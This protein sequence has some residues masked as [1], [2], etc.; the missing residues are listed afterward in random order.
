MDIL[1]KVV[2]PLGLAFIM[3]SL[4]L[5]LKGADFYRVIQRPTSFFI[6]A[7]NQMILLPIVAFVIIIAFGISGELAVGLM[8]LAA[9]PG[10][11]TSNILSR[12]AKADVAL[13]VT[14]TA[15]ISLTT[16]IT[17][18]II[19]SFAFGY[20]MA[21]QASPVNITITAIT[22]FALTVVPIVLALVAQRLFPN[23]MKRAAPACS[24]IATILFA[25]IIIAALAT[26]WAFFLENVQIIGGALACLIIILMIIGFVVPRLLGRSKTEAKTISIETG[27]QNG[28]LG[29]AIAALLVGGDAG[30][31]AYSIPSAVYGILMY[32]ISLPFVMLFRRIS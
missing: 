4:G 13:S 25:I 18:P 27:I 11:V 2:L 20:F 26:N 16:V 15:V 24:H 22:M 30:F 19:L 31:T 8:I 1:V 10:G 14:L 28:T 32:F 9:C 6:G 5:G 17:V 21:G 7:F 29:I 3:F 23:A 12:L